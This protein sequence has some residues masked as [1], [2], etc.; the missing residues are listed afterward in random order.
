[1]DR[2]TVVPMEPVSKSA[3]EKVRKKMFFDH[4]E[5]MQ[6][7]NPHIL[8]PLGV[9]KRWWQF[10]KTEHPFTSVINK[11]DISTLKFGDSITDGTRYY[12]VCADAILIRGVGHVETVSSSEH[13]CFFKQ[14]DMVWLE[15]NPWLAEAVERRRNLQKKQQQQSK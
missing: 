15:E 9:K 4:C 3:G 7:A 6:R 10:T 2:F 12:K 8:L 14:G 5:K 13:T 11:V 1:M